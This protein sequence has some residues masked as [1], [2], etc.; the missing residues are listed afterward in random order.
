V[1][2]VGQGS[3]FEIWDIAACPRPP[4][5]GSRCTCNRLTTRRHL[6]GRDLRQGRSQQVD[7]R[8]ARPGRSAHR[9]RP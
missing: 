2:L 9:D 3:H 7:S 6:R 8:E 5:P 4:P 1:M